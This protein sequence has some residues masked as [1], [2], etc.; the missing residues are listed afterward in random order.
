MALMHLEALRHIREAY[1]FWNR[2]GGA[3]HIWLFAHDEGACWAPKE[4]YARSVILTH[5]GRLGDAHA[6]NSG[7]AADNYTQDYP[8]R[9]HPLLA[10][11]WRHLIDGHACYTPGKDLVVPAA[12]LPPMLR[13]SP[14]LGAPALPRATL[15]FFRGDVGKERDPRYSRGI[16]QAVYRLARDNGWAERYNILVGDRGDVPGDYSK[17]LASSKYCL[18]APGAVCARVWLREI[19]DAFA[20]REGA[21]TH[22]SHRHM[23]T[24]TQTT[25]T[26]QQATDS[27]CARRT[28][29][30][31]AACRSS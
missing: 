12:K 31:T 19:N 14:L 23:H 22:P 16:R 7:Y 4:V 6:S 30:S 10:P 8:E 25:Q 29:C 3:D 13:W 20:G 28:R 27:R 24:P 2:T 9:G 17:L 1:P 26:A 18:V 15:L 5:W 11:G 21:R